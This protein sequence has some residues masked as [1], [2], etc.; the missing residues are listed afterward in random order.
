MRCKGGC[1]GGPCTLK[2][3]AQVIGEIQKVAKQS[4]KQKP[5]F[6]TPKK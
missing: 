5:I 1:V 6:A 2:T 3:Q 4:P